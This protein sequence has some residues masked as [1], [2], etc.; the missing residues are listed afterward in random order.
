[1]VSRLLGSLQEKELLFRVSILYSLFFNITSSYFFI[2]KDEWVVRILG[3]NNK[4]TGGQPA[5]SGSAVTSTTDGAGDMHVYYL[6]SDNHV[7]ELAWF[8][9]SWHPRDVTADAANNWTVV[10]NT[11]GPI[12]PDTV[13]V[14]CS[15]PLNAGDVTANPITATF[16]KSG[17][18]ELRATLS[19]DSSIM[20]DLVTVGF[21]LKNGNLAAITNDARLGPGDLKTVSISGTDPW[22]SNHWQGV[23]NSEITFK[24]WGHGDWLGGAGDLFDSIYDFFKDHPEVIALI[25][26][27]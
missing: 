15:R 19:S 8:G 16:Y 23:V 22:I 14:C 6:G 9:G 10:G 17:N 7:Y 18:W 4:N 11:G 12:M 24:F 26:S 5:I 13:E 3:T 21:I 1:M 25:G 27:A 20:D 2:T